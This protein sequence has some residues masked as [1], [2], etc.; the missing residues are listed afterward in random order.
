MGK[1]GNLS[2]CSLMAHRYMELLLILDIS[3]EVR[4]PSNDCEGQIGRLDRPRFGCDTSFNRLGLKTGQTNTYTV[5]LLNRLHGFPE[6]LHGLDLLVL[7]QGRQLDGVSHLG[8]SCKTRPCDHSSLTFNGE[9][10][11][12]CKEEVFLSPFLSIRYLHLL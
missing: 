4:D 12:N 11:I 10:V 1:E 9:T 2:D 7:L 6:H 8:F 5:S 3:H